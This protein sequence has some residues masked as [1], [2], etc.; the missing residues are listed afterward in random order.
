MRIG[1]FA[2]VCGTKISVLRHYDKL[3]LIKPDYI[4]RFT[5]Y[6][7]YSA[8]Q[9][10]VFR[11]ITA[12]KGAGFT[13]GEIK[14]LLP[15]IRE[16][17]YISSRVEKKKAECQKILSSLENVCKILYGGNEMSQENT[18]KSEETLFLSQV[19]KADIQNAYLKLK[20]QAKETDR[21]RVSGLLTKENEDGTFEVF[22]RV[23]PLKGEKAQINEDIN[24]P[25][26]DDPTVVGRW[27]IVGEYEVRED[28]D[29][30]ENPSVHYRKEFKEIYFLPGGERYWCYGWTK[31]KLLTETGDGSAVNSY[32]TE[33]IGGKHYMFIEFKSYY[34]KRGGR[35]VLLVLRQADN[36]KYS[37]AGLSRKD[38]IDLPFADDRQVI[39]KWKSVAFIDKKSQFSP[40]KRNEPGWL[41]WRSVEFHEGGNCTTEFPGETISSPDAQTWTKGYIL[42]KYNT[43][44]CAYE[45]KKS[46]GEEYLIVEWKSGDYRWGGFETN[47][48][49]FMRA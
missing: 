1:E 14:A 49:V 9:A 44:A 33:Y 11:I 10:E 37:R 22:I 38:N 30:G 28:F 16:R 41:Y 25:F 34:Y 42:R 3:G 48:Y 40:G 45:I 26:E 27:E 8:K 5:G 19:L 6:R 4:D 31:G 21:Q 39:G 17:E 20:K 36:E 12:L 15:R 23:V 24:L 29:A 7:Y 43:N 13:L 47:Y 35:P 2:A 46:G 32:K 18:I